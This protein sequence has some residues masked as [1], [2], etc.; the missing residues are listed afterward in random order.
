M[1]LRQRDRTT[2]ASPARLG[3]VAGAPKIKGKVKFN[4]NGNGNGNN[5]GNN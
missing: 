4:G 2:P 5:D 3:G 1:G